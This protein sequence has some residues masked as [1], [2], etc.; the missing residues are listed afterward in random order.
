MDP[1]PDSSDMHKL[2]DA[3]IDGNADDGVID[4]LSRRLNEDAGVR[5]AYIGYMSLEAELFAVSH[6]PGAAE[7]ANEVSTGAVADSYATDSRPS[8]GLMASG[9]RKWLTQWFAIG[10][11][12]LIASGGSS[13]LT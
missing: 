11:S 3:M 5:R 13:W 12:I 9:G 10:A 7:S 8:R 1:T 6:N 2:V 4:E